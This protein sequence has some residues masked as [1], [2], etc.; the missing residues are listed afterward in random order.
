MRVSPTIRN[1]SV[2]TAVLSVA[3]AGLLLAQQQQPE[4]YYGDQQQTPTFDDNEPGRG[5]A[6]ISLTNG[7]VNFKRGDTNDVVAAQINAPLMA[8]DSL[9]T[10]PGARAEIQFD[11]AN[12]LR[13]SSATEVRMSELEWQ[14][15][16]VQLAGGTMTFRTLRNSDAQIEINTPAVAIR[17]MKKGEYRIS[18][19]EDGTT[20]I[21]VRSGEVEIFTPRGSERLKSGKKMLA[22]MAQGGDPEFQV[23]S[24][25]A[26]DEF[27]MWNQDR[28]RYLERSQSYG[29]VSPDVYGTEDLDANGTWQNSPQYGNVWVPNGV[30]PDWAPYQDGRWVYY[31]YYGW[32]WVSNDPWGWA[33]YHYGRWYND[34]SL[35]WAWW[36]GQRTGR[37][38]W[39]PA[40]VSFFGW[41]NRGGFNLNIGFGFGNVGWVPLA[42]YEPCYGWWGRK[43]Y[44]SWGNGR[45]YNNTMIVNNINVVNVYRNARARNGI[46]SVAAGDFGRNRVYAGNIVRGRF[47]DY[48]GAGVVRGNLPLVPD[49]GASL[50]LNDRGAGSFRGRGAENIRFAQTRQPAPINRVSFEDQ[51]R[52]TQELAR[53]SFGN[54]GEGFSGRGNAESPRFG[55]NAES[56]RFGGG[57]AETPRG[58]ATIDNG[59]WRRGR[60]NDGGNGFDP[61]INGQVQRSSPDGERSSGGWRRFG[62]SRSGDSESRQ[63]E[64]PQVRSPRSSEGWGR[65]GGNSG[66]MQ[67]QEQPQQQ[68]Q[69]REIDANSNRNVWRQQR[70]MER[71][72][73]QQP[74]QPSFDSQ[75]EQIRISPP[76]VRDRSS[77]GR[78]NSGF[79]GFGGFGGRGNNNGGGG[80]AERQQ[81]RAPRMER[82]NF[83]GGG[84]EQRAPRMERPSFEGR[85]G[86]G[87]VSSPRSMESRG[88]GGGESGRGGGGERGGRSGGGGGRNR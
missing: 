12:A 13:M 59:G 85:G 87:G 9:L 50:R 5:V 46:T 35:G 43:R 10:G 52:G 73:Q 15:Y 64:Q 78:S 24:A 53:R 27:D 72:Q 37:H 2:A 40:Y 83:G 66:R 63:Q 6:R 55:G 75:R 56:P 39:R 36:P 7:E 70:S 16:M 14:R 45:F 57:N 34:P 54:N 25:P 61:N 71:T 21:T 17:P 47:D 68:Q 32:T 48:R 18:V 77:E 80:D 79:G 41:G 58:G 38:F 22:R 19:Y 88:G 67:S 60:G 44:N 81:Q 3:A 23:A 33:P 62:G 42:P 51:R 1:L 74:D 28:D 11:S 86:G 4:P 76:I 65:F 82:P 8:G 30:G 49:R 69:Q 31:D 26:R 29:Q 84:G 20:E